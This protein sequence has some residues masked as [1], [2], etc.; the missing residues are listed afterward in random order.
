M[1]Q[2]QLIGL[3]GPANNFAMNGLAMHFV[4][5]LMAGGHTLPSCLFMDVLLDKAENLPEYIKT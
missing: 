3:G 2:H 4:H 1:N 5:I